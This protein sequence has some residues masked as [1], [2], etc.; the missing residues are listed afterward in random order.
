M[1][2]LGKLFG[3]REDDLESEEELT[4]EDETPQ[5]FP[6]VQPA[7]QAP[8]SDPLDLSTEPEGEDSGAQEEQGE[9]KEEGEDKE[10]GENKEDELLELFGTASHE[11]SDLGTLVSEIE[12]VP[13]QDLV[14]ELRSVAAAL[15]GGPLPAEEKGEEAA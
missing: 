4:E 6:Q 13:V 7:A 12:D 8:E 15:T 10:Q 14:T 5:A 3:K 2:A 9:E 1:S 11:R